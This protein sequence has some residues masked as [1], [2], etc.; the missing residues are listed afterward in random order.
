MYKIL[1]LH[2]FFLTLLSAGKAQ[3]DSLHYLITGTYTSGR[4]EGIYVYLFNS[5]NGT[6][7]EISH[8]KT[9]NPSFVTVSADGK[10][11]Y[12]VN[13][14]SN[15]D[16]GG[17][18]SSFGFDK[19]T[20]ILTP[21]NKQLTAGDDPCYIDIDK[22]GKWIFV[23]N[24]S[25]GTLSVLPVDASGTIG[26]A[27]TTIRH[28]GS[29]VNKSRQEKPHVH[30]T[31]IS[32]DNKWLFVPDLGIDKVMI[33]GFDANNGNLTHSKQAF[34][35]INDGG[36]PRHITFH[37]NNKYAYVIEEMS[38]AVNAY[39]YADGRFKAIQ[40]IKSVQKEDTGFVGSADI[41]VSLDGKFLYTSNRGGFNT[42]AIYKINQRD[43]KLTL[44]GHQ[45]SLGDFPRNFTIDPSG[46]FLLVANQK[47]DDV[48]IF[49]RNIKTGLLTSTGK[50][51]SVGNPVCLKW[52]NIK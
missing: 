19:N 17:E 12:A 40:Q 50:R 8:V 25:S 3:Q 21:I 51:I 36:G 30:C 37:P 32:H 46:K 49:K 28:E 9:S 44:L 1:S 29:G 11:V 39:E 15:K 42:I 22:T 27:K 52:I 23:G 26:E 4:S 7:K 45:K 6:Y 31:Y 16:N 18:V 14:N 43:G 13:E 33:Y 48:V 20:G 38:G 2:V 35:K 34:I 5:N 10:F 47:S 41:H 24:Y